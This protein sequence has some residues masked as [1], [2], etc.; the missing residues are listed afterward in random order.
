MK[1]KVRNISYYEYMNMNKD[2]LKIIL[3]LAAFLVI[4][5]SVF[6]M[7]VFGFKNASRI[8]PTSVMP[9]II[10][11]KEM[12]NL[13]QKKVVNLKLVGPSLMQVGK[14]YEVQLVATSSESVPLVS[15][16]TYVNFTPEMVKVAGLVTG[17]D[18][19]KPAFS[20]ANQTKGVVVANILQGQPVNLTPGSNLVIETFSVTPSK[21]GEALFKIDTGEGKTLLVSNIDS[22][23]V[24]FTVEN[25]NVVVSK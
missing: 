25:L 12:E 10:Q 2:A 6:I 1:D 23:V 15:L 3:P 20:T 7:D 9:T 24:G 13:T 11:V 22:K 17:K 18:L 19:D 4:I 5:L 21:A 14:K 8:V 16:E